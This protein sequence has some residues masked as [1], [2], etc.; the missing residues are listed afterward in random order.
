MQF[1]TSF[2]YSLLL[3]YKYRPQN[4]NL[5]HLKAHTL[6]C[7]LETMWHTIQN[8]LKHSASKYHKAS[9]YAVPS[10][11]L[12]L[13]IL[14]SKY[15]PQNPI[16]KHLKAHTLP[17][18]SETM[19]HTI[20]KTGRII[21][22]CIFQVADVTNTSPSSKS[23]QHPHESIQSPWRRRQCIPPKWWTFDHNTAQIYKKDNH[24]INANIL[25]T[26]FMLH[27]QFSLYNLNYCMQHVTFCYMHWN[28]SQPNLQSSPCSEVLTLA[29]RR[30]PFISFFI[31]A[32]VW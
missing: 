21:V 8:L 29:I 6:P 4:P 3:R 31:L 12:L 9:H 28:S 23:L 15:R 25:T 2:H 5:K 1:P 16:L 19:W 14:R 24:F 13:T 11:L 7:I 10:I 17:W 30:P 22:L 32:N 18:M 26:H 27:S 20:Q